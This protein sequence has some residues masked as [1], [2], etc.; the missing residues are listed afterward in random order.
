MEAPPKGGCLFA[1]NS[2]NPKCILISMTGKS[3]RDW[4]IRIVHVVQYCNLFAILFFSGSNSFLSFFLFALRADC[5]FK[6]LD[7]TYF[8]RN[9]SP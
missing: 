8:M 1:L 2:E 4:D 6:C 9:R 7:V 3:H 5:Q